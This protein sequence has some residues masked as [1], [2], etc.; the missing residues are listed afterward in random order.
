[1]NF[2]IPKIFTSIAFDGGGIASGTMVVAFILPICVG[3]SSALG[4]D[5]MLYAFGVAG[6]VA[7]TPILTVQ[8]LGLIFMIKT[9]YD[10]KKDK[11]EKQI[12]ERL[13][14]EH[15]PLSETISCNGDILLDKS[16]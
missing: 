11:K 10:K 1:M 16:D 8:I 5:I 14:K 15:A 7:T 2:I 9:S 4:Q 12:L 6:M 3:M 13:A